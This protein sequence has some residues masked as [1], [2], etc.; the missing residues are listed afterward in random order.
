[1]VHEPSGL[2]VTSMCSWSTI[3]VNEPLVGKAGVAVPTEITPS[4]VAPDECGAAEA[5]ARWTVT[6]LPT[7]LMI[8][9]CSESMMM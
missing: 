2:T 5:T 9:I 1:M 6:V 3:I 7:M 8:S 4:T